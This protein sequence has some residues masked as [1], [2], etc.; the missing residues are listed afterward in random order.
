MIPEQ[1]PDVKQKCPHRQKLSI[2]ESSGIK[3]HRKSRMAKS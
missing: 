1:N 2:Q 3:E